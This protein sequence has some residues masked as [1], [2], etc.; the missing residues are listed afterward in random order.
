MTSPDAN[1]PGTGTHVGTPV[2]RI[3]DAEKVYRS[4]G[5]EETRAVAKV[6]FDVSDGEFISIVGPSGCGKTTLM[7][8]C[9]GL[10]T[11]TSGAID[12]QGTG[13]P[14]Q[15]GHSGIAF[16]TSSL[17]PWRTILSNVILPADILGLDKDKAKKRAEELLALVRLEGAGP[18]Y[19]HELS[20]GMQQRA[21]ICRA[22]LHDPDILFMDEPFGALDAMTRE[23]LNMQLQDVHMHENKTVIFITHSIQEAVLLSDRVLVMSKGPGR[24][25]ADH[26][27]PFQRPRTMDTAASPEFGE[28]AG[29]IRAQLHGAETGEAA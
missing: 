10:V 25:V 29:T 1:Q 12:Y 3:R 6:N 4:K 28:L 14:V 26:R 21:S 18:K 8:M 19:P 20:G 11:I 17:L 16:Q 23:E 15:P 7:K 9:A 22:L 24:L 27:I 5:G 13:Q 2:L